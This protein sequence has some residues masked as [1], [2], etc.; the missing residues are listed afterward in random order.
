[1]PSP[2]GALTPE[3]GKKI[4]DWFTTHWKADGCPICGGKDLAIEKNT[5]RVDVDGKPFESPYY[6]TILVM[7][8]ICA[9]QMLF[10]AVKIGVVERDAEKPRTEVATPQAE[11]KADARDGANA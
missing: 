11:A 9:H 5:V 8:R 6:P 7:C 10:N 4:E 1:M 2:D 3:E